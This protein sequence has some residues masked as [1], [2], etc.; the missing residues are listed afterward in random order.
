[1][2]TVDGSAWVIDSTALDKLN[3]DPQ[4]LIKCTESGDRVV[5]SLTGVH[6][7]KQTMVVSHPL[8]FVVEAPEEADNGSEP[9]TGATF[10][11]PDTGPFV[12]IK[13]A[14]TFFLSKE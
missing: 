11:C 1:M 6:K 7:F 2:K 9:S 10:T 5:F 14:L 4:E 12:R 3:N 13:Y 8:E